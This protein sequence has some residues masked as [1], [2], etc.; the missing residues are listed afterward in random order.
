MNIPS[1]KKDELSSNSGKSP[2]T[3]IR[4]YIFI[5]LL[6]LYSGTE[7]SI[8]GWLTTYLDSL[9]VMNSITPQ[10]I[11]SI[12]WIAII[13][14]RLISAGISKHLSREALILIFCIG[15]GISYVLFILTKNP[16]LISIWVFTLGFFFAGTYPTVVA[17]ASSIIRGSGS[18]AGIMLSFGGMG[19]AFFPYINGQIA[20]AKGLYAGM[21]AIVVSAA[22]LIIIAFVNYYLESKTSS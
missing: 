6:F 10:D 4:Y 13:L 16:I 2:F 15:G 11:L 5:A 20:D 17:N 7:K 12:F 1:Q 19:G 8:N 14:G 18:A 9:G 3:N 21:I 22:L